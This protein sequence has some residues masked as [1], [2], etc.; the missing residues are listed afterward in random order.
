MHLIEVGDARYGFGNNEFD[1]DEQDG[2]AVLLGD[3]GL[4]QGDRFRYIYDFG[5]DWQHLVTVEAV[6]RDVR[7]T[8]VPRL[9][10]GERACPPED[11]G[12]VHGYNELL[13]ALA[14]PGARGACV[15]QGMAGAAV[16]SGGVRPR[17]PS[18]PAAPAAPQTEQ[19]PAN[20]AGGRAPP[21]HD[22]GPHGP[23]Q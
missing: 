9:I 10:G 4:R 20:C 6:R 21:R 5:D 12:G 13:E 7:S 15:L 1:E 16:G 2:S 14:G 8:D 19:A 3:L 22:A 11:C 18:A 17:I 23:G